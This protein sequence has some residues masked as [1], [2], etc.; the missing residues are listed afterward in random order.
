M[1]IGRIKTKVTQNMYSIKMLS[2]LYAYNSAIIL[3][4]I[5]H[6]YSVNLLKQHKM[7]LA[8]SFILQNFNEHVSHLESLTS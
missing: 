2:K 3:P 5:Q 4:K 1:T 6:I 7:T 8:N